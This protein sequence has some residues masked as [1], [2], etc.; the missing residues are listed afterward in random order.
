MKL[1][2]GF[3]FG[4]FLAVGAALACGPSDEEIRQMVQSET[5][6]WETQMRE[7]VRAEVAELELPQGP[8]GPQGAQGERGVQGAQ[9]ERGAQGTQGERGLQGRQGERGA[10]GTQ[11]PAGLQGPQGEQGSQG[12][13]GPA[14]LQGPQGEQGLQG[15]QGPQGERGPA[16]PRGEQGP[17]GAAGSPAEIPDVFETL[18]VRELRVLNDEGERAITLEWNDRNGFPTIQLHG[19]TRRLGETSDLIITTGDNTHLYCIW[20]NRIGLCGTGAD[21]VLEFFED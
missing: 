18:S 4:V 1:S 15:T 16:G 20:G 3:L 8:A 9:G 19:P 7:A 11:G 2:I 10:Q 17:R 13:Q 14:G 6:Q 21:G 5:A 12:T